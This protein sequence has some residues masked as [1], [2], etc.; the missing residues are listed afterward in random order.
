LGLRFPP[1][2]GVGHI[3]PSRW[4]FIL[5]DRLDHFNALIQT[6]CLRTPQAARV[7]LKTILV[8]A[9]LSFSNNL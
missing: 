1:W 2:V 7:Q 8:L 9:P 3:A 4:P 5:G 6:T